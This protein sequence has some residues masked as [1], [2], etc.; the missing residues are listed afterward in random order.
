MT[1]GKQG[2]AEKFAKAREYHRRAEVQQQVA[3][4]LMERVGRLPLPASPKVLEIGC[5]SGLLSQLLVNQVVDGHFLFS[6]LSHAMVQRARAGLASQGNY[7]F[8]VMDGE[9]PSVAGGFDLIISSLAI[10]WF[11]APAAALVA[12]KNLLNP[13]GILA[14]AGLG[15]Q[16]FHQWRAACELAG[17]PCRTP[18]YPTLAEMA[19]WAGEGGTTEE[20]FITVERPSALSFF[21]GLRAVGAHGTLV[22]APPLAP[23]LLRRAL[24]MAD[25]DGSGV[26][27]TYHILFRMI[28]T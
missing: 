15:N 20:G 18:N 19:G 7:P 16:T 25:G 26:A 5:G 12:W 1:G 2:V 14:V 21:Q 10:Q 13:G 4:Q 24:K 23:N 8:V 27:M 9:Q 22:Q 11:L 28:Q 6:D 3:R 17:V